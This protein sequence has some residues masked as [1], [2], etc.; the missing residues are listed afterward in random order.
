[1]NRSFGS[2]HL[3]K[4]TRRPPPT[5]SPSRLPPPSLRSNR[6]SESERDDDSDDSDSGDNLF[7]DDDDD[8]NGDS[9]N[10]PGVTPQFLRGLPQTVL[11][12]LLIDIEQ[13]HGGLLGLKLTSLCNKKPDIYGRPGS[14]LR[15]KVQNKT[16]RLKQLS[17]SDY[18]HVLNYFNVAS[19]LHTSSLTPT[20]ERQSTT[21]RRESSRPQPA[22][23]SPSPPRSAHFTRTPPPSRTFQSPQPIRDSAARRLNMNSQKYADFDVNEVVGKLSPCFMSCHY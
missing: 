12:Q 6:I 1:M 4:Q 17:H 22:F 15:R 21:P 20:V 13:A 10:H 19:G 16:F 8:N 7:S 14:A 5:P 2:S 11:K 18:L 9:G 23:T 3:R